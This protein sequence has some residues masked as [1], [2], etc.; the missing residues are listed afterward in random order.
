MKLTILTLGFGFALVIGCGGGSP[1]PQTALE[2]QSIQQRDFEAPKDLTFAA[3]ISV[4]QDLGYIVG[5]ADTQTGFITA[6]G[7]TQRA[8][9]RTDSQSKVTAFVESTGE[10]QTRVRLNFVVANAKQACSLYTCR[11]RNEDDA[12]TD[13]AIY[14]QAFDKIGEAVFVRMAS[15]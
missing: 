7:A 8:N 13:P 12:I 11:V 9:Y 1:P 2:L 10:E 14:E 6:Q 3:T 15:R 4:L 5:G